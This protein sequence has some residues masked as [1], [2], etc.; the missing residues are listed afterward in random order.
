M[1]NQGIYLLDEP[2]AAL[3]PKRLIELLKIIR[4]VEEGG[5]GQLI[6]VTHSPLIMAYPTAQFLYFEIGKVEERDYRET[7]HFQLLKDFFDHPEEFIA[8]AIS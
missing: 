4:I 7:E 1:N 6:I 3:S 2:E 5:M 8:Q